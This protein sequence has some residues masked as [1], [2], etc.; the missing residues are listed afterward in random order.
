MTQIT[1]KNSYSVN[2]P[3][4]DEQHKELITVLNELY[5]ASKNGMAQTILAAILEKLT[6][7]SITHFQYEENL[8]EKHGFDKI[9]EHKDEHSKF[10]EQLQS[11]TVQAA[12]GNLILSLK[13][14]DFLKDWLIN[15]TL[16]TDHDYSEFLVSKGVS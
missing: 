4:I 9:E 12:K 3:S 10:I 2:I 6:K 5:E 11:F 15:H 13:T 8:M 7:Y 16:G 1:W 14:I